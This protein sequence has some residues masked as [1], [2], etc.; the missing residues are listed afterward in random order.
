MLFALDESLKKVCQIT[1]S[2]KRLPKYVTA[3]FFHYTIL[4]LPA[5]THFFSAAGQERSCLKLNVKIP[6]M[7]HMSRA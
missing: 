5:L 3:L 4:Q 6:T 1:G 2:N 7:V